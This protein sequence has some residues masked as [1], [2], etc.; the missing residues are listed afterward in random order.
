MK[1][2]ST[3][4]SP[5]GELLL[6]ADEKGLT[7]I[8]FKEGARFVGDG[9]SEDAKPADILAEDDP[10]REF[11]AETSRWLDVYFTGKEPAFFP[12]FHLTGSPF[13]QLIGEL[14]FKVPYGSTTTYGELAKQAAERLGRET[15]SF[16]AVGGAVGHNP[17]SILVPCHRVIGT[18]GTL[19]GYGGGLERKKA[20][21]ELE[22]VDLWV[23]HEGEQLHF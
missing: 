4:A 19:T 17:L 3:Y 5:L 10:I 20:L 14:M 16:R 9:L 21:L 7:G 11:F 2:T 6:A 12:R 22:G 18:D 13:R 8:W 1:Y 15:M 23:F